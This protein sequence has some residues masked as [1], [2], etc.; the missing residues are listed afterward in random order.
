M[1]NR[2]QAQ[3]FKADTIKSAF[4]K[5]GL[6]PYNPDE[7]MHTLYKEEE[8]ALPAYFNM[9]TIPK[10]ILELEAYSEKLYRMV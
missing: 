7:V 6:F 10:K 5:T 1:F 4:R 8:E 2:I 9:D 3:T